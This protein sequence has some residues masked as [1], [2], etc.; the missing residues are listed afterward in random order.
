LPEYRRIE[1][2]RFKEAQSCHH[3]GFASGHGKEIAVQNNKSVHPVCPTDSDYPVEHMHCDVGRLQM[4]ES[5]PLF[6]EHG[7]STIENYPLRAD[8][9]CECPGCGRPVTLIKVD[10]NPVTW[11]D[12]WQDEINR[13][14]F[15]LLAGPHCCGAQ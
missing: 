12:V 5:V 2:F 4:L 1:I 15:D 8:R 6:R 9:H 10:M 14:T 13:W 3:H 7:L 11:V